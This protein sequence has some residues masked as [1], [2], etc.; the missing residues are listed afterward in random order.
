MRRT[1]VATAVFVFLAAGCAAPLEFP[2]WVIPVAEDTPIVEYSGVAVDERPDDAV[3]G[4]VVDLRIGGGSGDPDY[5]FY[6]PRDVAVDDQG[7]IHVLDAGDHVVRSYDA[8]GMY[9]GSFGAEGQGPGEFSRPYE[10]AF[11]AG[12]LIVIDANRV[13]FWSPDGT[14]LR[15]APL[16]AQ[17]FGGSLIGIDDGAMVGFEIHFEAD[18]SGFRREVFISRAAAGGEPPLRLLQIPGAMVEVSAGVPAVFPQL[19]GEPSGRLYVTAGEE[20]QV[21]ALD[22]AGGVDRALRVTWRR[23]PITEEIKAGT[24]DYFDQLPDVEID[25]P[26]LMPALRNV[27]GDGHGHLYVFPYVYYNEAL[28]MVQQ[29]PRFRVEGGAE[30]MPMPARLPVDVYA[31]DGNR[32]FSGLIETNGDY[33]VRWNAARGDHVVRIHMD[34]ESGEQVVERLRLVETF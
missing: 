7:R 33:I 30:P 21:H 11:A 24:A 16:P 26:E 18:E 27:L 2:D 5:A 15:D 14:H 29:N 20:Y 25:W 3:I 22:A 32:L 34:P 19:V 9:R 23:E 12:E 10:L 6:R 17:S 31:A 4:A 28:L 8:S 1:S 13:S